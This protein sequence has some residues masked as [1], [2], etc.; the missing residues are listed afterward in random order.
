MRQE[1]RLVRNE[2]FKGES[3]IE[4]DFAMLAE[5][6]AH[7]QDHRVGGGVHRALH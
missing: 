3:S 4:L 1:A 6:Y 5:W 2:F 7:R